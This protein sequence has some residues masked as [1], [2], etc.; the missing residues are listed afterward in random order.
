M[1]FLETLQANRGELIRLKTQFYWYKNRTWDGN[2]GLVCLILDALDS[3]D[4]VVSIDAFVEGSDK[5][6]FADEDGDDDYKIV[7]AQLLIDG[8]PRWVGLSKK[9][10]ELITKE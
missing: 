9:N 1:T 3:D 10:I 4:P 5:R 7:F 2:T 6:V 8:F